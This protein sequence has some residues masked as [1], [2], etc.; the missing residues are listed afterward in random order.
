VEPNGTARLPHDAGAAH[1]TAPAGAP[2]DTPFRSSRRVQLADYFGIPYDLTEH[3]NGNGIEQMCAGNGS[4]LLWPGAAVLGRQTVSAGIEAGSTQR[5]PI[6]VP[7]L[8]DASA[9]QLLDAR[10]GTWSRT[11]AVT[12]GNGGRIGSIWSESAGSIFV[13]FDPDEICRSFWSE[14]YLSCLLG[15]AGSR[16]Q[17]GLML[18]YYGVRGLIPRSTQIWLRRRYSRVQARTEFPRW[19]VEP[20]LH[21]FFDLFLN[22]LAAVAGHPVPYL[23]PW[24]KD[25]RWAVVLTHD[26]ETAAGLAAMEPVLDLERS[27]GLRSCWNFVPERYEVADTYVRELI[28][29]GFEAGVHGLRHDGRDLASRSLQRRLPGMRAAAERWTAS[30]FRAPSMHRSWGLMPQLGFEYDSSSPDTDVFEPQFGGCCSWW[31]FFNQNLVELP[32]TM[33]QDHTLFVILDREDESAWIEKAE[34]LRRRS[35]MALIVTHPDYM[36]PPHVMDAYR[37]FLEHFVDDE[38]AWKALPG[39]VN[40]WW[41]RRAASRIEPDGDGWRVSGPA[42][43]E[44]RIELVGPG[45]RC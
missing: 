22:L 4:A 3:T 36:S 40:Q 20:A 25:H 38:T 21:D 44:A 28:S 33:P 16:A 45:V 17:S 19:P 6:F 37:S 30:G 35:G 12:G 34:F 39:E 13:P 26:V 32:M 27:L 29:E 31:P 42:A 2:A 5:I 15:H 23:A 43:E 1:T 41:R 7:V 18:G 9:R 8:D 10:P 11:G 24:P 14:R